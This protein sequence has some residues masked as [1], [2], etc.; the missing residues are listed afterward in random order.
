MWQPSIKLCR[1]GASVVLC[2]VT[3]TKFTQTLVTSPTLSHTDVLL[4]P[5]L[6]RLH[7]VTLTKP[8]TNSTHTYLTMYAYK[9]PYTYTI[10]VYRR[11]QPYTLK[12]WS[13]N[14]HQ[15][16]WAPKHFFFMSYTCLHCRMRRICSGIIP[17]ELE[18]RF[19]WFICH[20]KQMMVY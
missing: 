6:V 8:H 16:I 18:S 19:L 1:R 2:Y 4:I 17:D 10:C 3:N 15:S 7:L 5:H 9:H 14:T 13:P 20:F 12:Q 11:S